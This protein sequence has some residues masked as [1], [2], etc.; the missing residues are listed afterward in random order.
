[1]V[2]LLES[3]LDQLRGRISILEVLLDLGE[4]RVRSLL[5]TWPEATAGTGLGHRIDRDNRLD[6]VMDGAHRD[7]GSVHLLVP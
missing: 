2:Q 3:V 4:Q 5:S 1:M 6:S 7:A